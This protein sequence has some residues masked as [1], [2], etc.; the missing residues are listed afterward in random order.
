MALD[1]HA[2]FPDSFQKDSQN[3][4]K[5]LKVKRTSNSRIS[6]LKKSIN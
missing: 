4:E 1:K 2:F 5:G 3:R 6:F